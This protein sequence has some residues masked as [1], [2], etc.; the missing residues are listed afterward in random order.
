MLYE[1]ITNTFLATA[2]AALAWGAIEAMTRGKASM[3][4]VASG[5]VAGLVAITP[6]CGTIVITSYSIHYTKL[7]EVRPTR[8]ADG[9]A[10]A[11]PAV[12]RVPWRYP[13]VS[14]RLPLLT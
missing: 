10:P 8:S 12:P 3:L 5:I 9:F 4:G 13:V 11:P 6:A 2:A 7:Y 14:L 1:V